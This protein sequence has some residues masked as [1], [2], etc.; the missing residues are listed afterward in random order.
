ME[1]KNKFKEIK[2]FIKKIKI[3][4]GS[5][6]RYFERKYKEKFGRELDLKEPK[7]FN[8]KVIKRILFDKKDIYTQLADKYLVREYVKK[9]IGEDYLIRLYGVYNDVEEIKLDELPNKFVLKCNHDSGSVCICED[10]KIFDFIKAKEKLKKCLKKNFYYVTRE[11]QYKNIEP[12]IICEE[13]LNDIT[14]Y[15]I[16]CFAGK[17][18]Y[19]EVVF[20]RF[21]NIKRNIYDVNWRLQKYKM[22]EDENTE[23]EILKPKNLNEI[24]KTAEKLAEEFIYCRVDLYNDNGKIKFGEMTF[25]PSSGLDIMS[26]DF[27]LY[28]GR[29]WDEAEKFL[30]V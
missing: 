8:E 22:S 14:D 15:K 7:T 19:L 27:D 21:E 28:L 3:A 10:K 24:I 16:H 26:E 11:W 23:E 12:K 9:K 18:A 5:D 30:G 6:K 13:K 17:A 29:L 2:F 4:L 20:S 25:T 1:L